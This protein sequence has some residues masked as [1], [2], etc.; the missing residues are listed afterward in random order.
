MRELQA[1]SG[2]PEGKVCRKA[3][4][5]ITKLEA[6]NARLVEGLRFKPTPGE[7]FAYQA[8]GYAA[9]WR[10]AISQFEANAHA[11]LNPKSEDGSTTMGEMGGD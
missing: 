10:A 1:R 6:D 4:D 5:H 11:T 7:T 9:G 3:I 8:D 2:L